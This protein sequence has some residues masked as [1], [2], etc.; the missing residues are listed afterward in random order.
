MFLY[1]IRNLVNTMLFNHDDVLPYWFL[2]AD[3]HSSQG[4]RHHSDNP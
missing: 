3:W 4:G 2:L 1:S